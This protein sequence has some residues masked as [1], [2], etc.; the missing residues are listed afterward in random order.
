M[1]KF[2][3]YAHRAVTGFMLDCQADLLSHLHTRFVVPLLFEAEAPRPAKRL[4]PV[5]IVGN[6][7][8]VMATQYASTVPVKEL[9]EVVGSLLDRQDEVMNALD[10]LISGF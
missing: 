8:V 1:A 3:V 4:N 2:D 10:M 5:F 7:P 6:G 9:G